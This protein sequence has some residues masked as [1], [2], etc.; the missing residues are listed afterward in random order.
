VPA[1]IVAV[2]GR[3]VQFAWTLPSRSPQ[4]PE[5]VPPRTFCVDGRIGAARADLA[6][7]RSQLRRRRAL[8]VRGRRLLGS[9]ASSLRRNIGVEDPRSDFSELGVIAAISVNQFPGGLHAVRECPI[10][11]WS[12][13]EARPGESHQRGAAPARTLGSGARSA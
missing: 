5:G 4:L 7:D 6:R 2:I 1:G 3:D 9:Y 8:M 11:A 12:A 10:G 13:A